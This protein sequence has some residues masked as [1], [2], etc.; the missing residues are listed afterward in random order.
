MRLQ[1][2]N[3]IIFGLVLM[4]TV[5][6]GEGYSI[7]TFW[8]WIALFALA[9]I[10]ITILFISSKQTMKVQKLHQ[11]MLKKQLEMEKNQNILLT[12]MSENIHEI[13]KQAF[14]KSDY[15]IV[16]S[17]KFDQNKKEIFDNV[18]SKLLTVTT[19]L[20]DF[21]R[22][23]SKK[24]HITNEKFNINNVLNEISG[25]ICSRF[26]GKNAEL[27]FDIDHNVPRFMI[28]DSLHLG[29]ILHN[30]LDHMMEYFSGDEVKL[31]IAMFNTFDKKIEL[32]FKFTDNS[33]GM[34]AEQLESLFVP[35]YKEDKGTYVGLGLFV[36][37]ELVTMMHGEFSVQSTVG[38]GNI[39]ALTLPFNV[40]P[41]VNKRVYRLPE[42]V[43]S[44]RK[45]FI[46][47]TN[48]NSALA[49][50][51]TFAYFKHEVKVIT[52]DEFLKN[53]P[54]LTPYDIIVINESLFT[55]RLVEYL[56]KIKSTKEL[57]IIALNALLHSNKDSFV[58][59]IIDVHLFKPLNQERI[60]EMI[61]DM[62][63]IKVS[64][65]FNQEQTGDKPQAK[66]HK[67]LIVTTKNVTQVHF[68]DFKGKHVLI[69]EDNLINQKVVIS[70]LQQSGIHISIANNGQ[71][72]VDLLK[73]G[74]I[75]FDLVL[76]DINMPIMDGYTA[77]QMIRLDHK[78]DTLPIIAFT[79]LVLESEIR[80]MF[81]SGINAFLEK[82]LNI[83]KLYTAFAMYLSDVPTH[84]MLEEKIEERVYEEFAGLDVKQ[85]ISHTNNNEV[86]YME[87]IYEFNSVYGN[88]AE[89]FKKLVLEHRYEQV[90]MLCIDL[91]GLTGAI[92]ANDM[93][94][95]ITEIYQRLLYN[96]QELLPKYIERYTFE[97]NTLSESIQKVT[98]L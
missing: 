49:I 95:L 88:S 81:N 70:L 46:V 67:G 65:D 10:G 75:K 40:D 83:G 12:N 4:N 23:K 89:L 28:G 37:H 35:Y 22:L 31:E 17:E 71:E 26:S 45:V 87:I 90:K 74:K 79:A 48:Y 5:Y 38:K 93:H 53:I 19:D 86:L 59:E 69:A 1:K 8:I 63:D 96:K 2:S 52:K 41:T 61:I 9:T 21:L 18:E 60:L 30:I 73:N 42:K 3:V 20:I 27:I 68:K 56:K 25:S 6:A 14:D 84:T 58:N 32:Q 80:K 33:V 16:Q 43:F 7:E 36:A 13:A 47:D 91:Q 29:Q 72:A 51:K 78:Y 85:G 57:K 64:A 97:M 66:I 11:D 82:P 94:S 24:I 39:F 44:A 77:T 55:I 54:S 50:K 76:M 92:G 98:S 62:Y 15:N 34:D